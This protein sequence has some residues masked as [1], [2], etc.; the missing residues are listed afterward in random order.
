MPKIKPSQQGVT[1]YVRL[2][3][4]PE[5]QVEDLLEWLPQTC[6]TKVKAE[7]SLLEDCVDYDDYE[8]WFEHC[9]QKDSDLLE[10]EI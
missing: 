4:L 10:E 8:F 3:N 9:Y 5:K 7:E 6:L 1:E 2:A